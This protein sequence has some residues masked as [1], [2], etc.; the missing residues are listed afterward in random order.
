MKRAFTLIELLVVIAIIAILA[1][2]LFP[3]FAQAREA[4]KRTACLSNGR[5]I[6]MATMMYTSDH[7]D[8]MPIF[9]AYDEINPP[10]PLHRGVEVWVLPYAK[11]KEIF[12]SPTDTGGPYLN[13]STLPAWLRG[14]PTY[15]AA[16]GTSYRFTSCVF[17]VVQN[18]SIQNATVLNFNRPTT[19][20]SMEDPSNTRMMR[21]EMMPF[22]SRSILSTACDRYGYDCPPPGDYFRRWS[23]IGGTVIF[24]DGSA[25]STT[26]AGKFDEQR[27]NPEGRKSGEASNDPN[28]WTGTW[29][30]LC[31]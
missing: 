5:Q 20:G 13:R 15:F 2:I 4:A 17:S 9:S 29:Y 10:G 12:N 7:D 24:A 21:T 26:S 31:D 11:N 25:R 22:F 28:A 27:V 18:Y 14:K 23:P 3:V 30:S 16:Y 19:L 8:G 6:G 1:A